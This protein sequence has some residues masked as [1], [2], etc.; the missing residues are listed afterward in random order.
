MRVTFLHPDLG[1]GGAERLIV[2]AAVALQDR[3]HT[4]KVVTNQ[5]DTS[6]C[7][8]E[9]EQLDI[10]V[11]KW[12]PRSVL[13]K[14][15][16][17]CAYIRM[18]LAALYIC[19]FY[20]SDV[21]VSDQVSACLCVLRMFSSAKLVFYC[22]FPDMLLTKRET[23]AKSAY[24]FVLDSVEEWTTSMADVICVNSEFTA[25][26]V[27]Q[28]FPSLANRHLTVVYPSLNTNFFDSIERCDLSTF[29]PRGKR[30]IFTSLNRFEV[31]KNVKLALQA[32]EVL[33]KSLPSETFK[34]C[35]LVLAGGYDRLNAENAQYFGALVDLAQELDMSQDQVSFIKS[36]SDEVKVNLLRG[37]RAVL[38]T[39][40]RE[41]FGIVPIEAM[42]L[43]A[44][45]IAV[46]SG[47]P[48]E[49]V[50]EGETGFLVDQTP[51]A[52]AEKMKMLI[53]DDVTWRKMSEKGTDR[54]RR[55][56]GFEAFSNRFDEIINGANS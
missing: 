28:T 23:V 20:R 29:I 25:A 21:I 7:F 44:P 31:K 9:T 55:F 43:G 34:K 32:F 18:C 12:F 11:V 47:G 40:D 17:L 35:L 37:S 3:G 33:R 27:R 8:K 4:V 38:Y 24:R 22:H 49:T 46:N 2:D 26:V 48:L 36:P 42:Y 19:M 52:F 15:N 30:Y 54:V 1:I 50:S 6:H 14:M 39:P 10:Q 41:H 13:G 16:A 56:F 51:E 45:V 5:F 53:Q